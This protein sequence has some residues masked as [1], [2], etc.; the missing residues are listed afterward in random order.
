[1]P[2]EITM[3]NLGASSDESRLVKW[4]AKNG[5]KVNKRQIIFEAESDKAV[6]EIEAAETGIIKHVIHEGTIIS[7]GQVVGLIYEDGESISEESSKI[8][9]IENSHQDTNER[10]RSESKP[11]KDRIFASPLAK[12]IAKENG[13]D[14]SL[15]KGSGPYNRIIKVDVENDKLNNKKPLPEIRNSETISGVRAR[16]A[17]KMVQ[18]HLTTVHSTLHSEVVADEIVELRGKLNLLL[19]DANVK[20]SYD[21]ILAIICAE[22]L[23]NH[24]NILVQ[25][26]TDQ[27]ITKN[28]IN[29]GIAVDTPKGLMVPV[30]KKV[31]Q[32]SLKSLAME[33]DG[34]I[35]R[36]KKGKG[37]VEDFSDGVFTISNLGLYRI[38]SFT[39]IINYPE[40]AILG[41]GKITKQ[42][43]VRNNQIDMANMMTLSLTY[44]HRLIDGAPAARF[45]QLIGDYIE[46]PGLLFFQRER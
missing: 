46:S 11:K 12:K 1:M 33:M 31:N 4:I 10:A 23:Q 41:I 21:L 36:I 32:K 44:D 14:L 5:E 29:I 28:E 7:S 2:K 13:I 30:L 26:Q 35:D 42:P 22:A 43:I 24:P 27:I 25:L 17:E 45:L 6:V 18:S 40:S 3:P 34:L 15:M 8:I 37:T 16:I 19:K 9:E 39:P 38:S 20:I